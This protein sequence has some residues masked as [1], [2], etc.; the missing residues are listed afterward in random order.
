DAGGQHPRLAGAG[1]GQHQHRAFGGLH[2]EALFRVQPGEIV[3]RASLAGAGRHGARGDA[4]YRRRRRRVILVEEGYVGSVAGRLA[5]LW[6]FGS[7]RPDLFASCSRG[8]GQVAL[9]RGLLS[10]LADAAG[11]EVRHLL[12]LMPME[13][14]ARSG[15]GRVACSARI[16]ARLARM[17]AGIGLTFGPAMSICRPRFSQVAAS[18]PSTWRSSWKK[19]KRFS[20][21][22]SSCTEQ[23][24]LSVRW[25]SRT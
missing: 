15:T 20:S 5:G 22:S 21:K 2:R 24:T 6:W 9:R 23:V 12:R 16:A 4:R 19:W 3:G 14:P 1:A 10:E 8:T 25:S 11:D 7:A 13:R 17:S 18:Q